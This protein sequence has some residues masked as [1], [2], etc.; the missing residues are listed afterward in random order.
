M[1]IW[2]DP[3]LA[4]N[5]DFVKFE[6]VGDTV[7]GTIQ[8]IKAHRFDDNNVVP[9]ILLT[10]ADGDEKTLT[11]GQ[12]KL[13]LLLL[14]QRPE[15]GDT[16]TITLTDI[17]KRGGGKTLKHFSLDVKRAGA[18]QVPTSDS[19]PAVDQAAVAAAMAAL[20]DEQKKALGIA[21]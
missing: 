7:T 2:D 21:V 10:T 16:V 3:E 13:K 8:T 20:S 11:A 1:S 6:N 19:G 5:N 12:T 15:V 9:Q 18:A 4:V 14:E 17:E